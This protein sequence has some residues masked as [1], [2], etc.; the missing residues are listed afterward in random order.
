MLHHIFQ[1]TLKLL[2]FLKHIRNVSF[3]S[4]MFLKVSLREGS[5]FEDGRSNRLIEEA[6]FRKGF[7]TFKKNPFQNAIFHSFICLCRA[8]AH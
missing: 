8:A 2:G 6:P 1:T 5:P 7:F 4:S 3:S